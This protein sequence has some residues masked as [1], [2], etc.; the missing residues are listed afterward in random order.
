MFLKAQLKM[1]LRTLNLVALFI[2]S[3]PFNRNVF[4]RRRQITQGCVS[5]GVDISA[6][7]TA[8]AVVSDGNSPLMAH[9]ARPQ[10]L[11]MLQSL[12]IAEQAAD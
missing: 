10:Q 1:T 2:I 7:T 9:S 12:C 5:T 11:L 6:S 3:Y 4:S 8:T